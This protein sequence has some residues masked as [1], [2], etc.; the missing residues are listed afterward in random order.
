M[1][2]DPARIPEMLALLERAWALVPDWRFG[3]L[4]F[5]ATSWVEG[6]GGEGD[7]FYVEDDEMAEGLRELIAR[8]ET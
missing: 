7:P 8:F 5:N 2:R 1:T 6:E 4:V 3:Q